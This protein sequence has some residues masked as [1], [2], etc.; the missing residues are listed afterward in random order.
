MGE[1]QVRRRDEANFRIHEDV[2]RTE[3]TEMM[4]E[5]EHRTEDDHEVEGQEEA[6]EETPESESSDDGEPIDSPVYHDMDK[7]YNSL[8]GFR[9]KYRLVKRIGEGT[10]QYMSVTEVPS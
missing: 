8:P 7:L 5:S 2:P 9:K 6:E 3:D 4:A 1:Q 10:S